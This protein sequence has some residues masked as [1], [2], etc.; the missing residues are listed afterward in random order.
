MAMSEEV[1]IPSTPECI[2]SWDYES[3]MVGENP[4]AVKIWPN[5][6]EVIGTVGMENLA[7]LVSNSS[8]FFNLTKG[9]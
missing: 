1:V 5:I 8:S 9:I 4:N 7:S 3:L 6:T 2:P